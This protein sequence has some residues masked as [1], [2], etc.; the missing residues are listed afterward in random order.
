MAPRKH[1]GKG[2]AKRAEIIDVTLDIVAQRGSRRLTN[3]EIA[4]KVGL[5]QAGLLHHFGSRDALFVEVLRTRDE[6]DRRRFWSAEPTFMGYLSILEHNTTVPGL[7]KLYVE[8]SAEATS[9]RHPAHAFFAERF[10]AV[11]GELMT[12]IEGERRSGKMGPHLDARA[13]AEV[14]IATTDGLQVQWLV[15][16]SVDVVGRLTRLW[17]GLRLASHTAP[18]NDDIGSLARKGALT[19]RGEVRP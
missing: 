6:R 3:R 18:D 16:N 7:V 12:A 9:R 14:V 2:V 19:P 15:D 13:A 4:A 11:R 17:M 5:T 1:Y 8:Y 10:E